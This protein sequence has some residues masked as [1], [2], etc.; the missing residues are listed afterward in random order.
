M[1]APLGILLQIQRRRHTVSRTSLPSSEMYATFA[2]VYNPTM[3]FLIGRAEYP[4]PGLKVS[5]DAGQVDSR[6]RI[7]NGPVKWA[8]S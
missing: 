2:G 5:T 3:R 7:R 4:G 6:Q 8:R 1:A